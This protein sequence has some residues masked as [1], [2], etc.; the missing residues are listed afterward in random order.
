MF[1]D[2]D[3]E[4]PMDAVS[5]LTQRDKQCDHGD[6]EG[7]SQRGEADDVQGGDATQSQE[8]EVSSQ[9]SEDSAYRLINSGRN[10]PCKDE[11]GSYYED[12]SDEENEDH[13]ERRGGN[14]DEGEG[15]NG[16]RGGDS[17]DGDGGGNN[18]VKG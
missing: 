8:G 15:S 1:G 4:I 3:D 13:D 18:M 12:I 6:V 16:K 7:E 5:E 10:T 11:N 14:E 9:L 17:G 2:S